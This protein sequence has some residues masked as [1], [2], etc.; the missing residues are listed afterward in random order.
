MFGQ[1]GTN[2]TRLRQSSMREYVLGWSRKYAIREKRITLSKVSSNLPSG[3][4]IFFL[5]AAKKIGTPNRTLELAPNHF[6]RRE[7]KLGRL[8]AG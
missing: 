3:V 6:S 5:P 1:F 4:P 2:N 7:K 8:I